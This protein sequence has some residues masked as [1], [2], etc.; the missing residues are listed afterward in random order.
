MSPSRAS[1]AIAAVRSTPH[2]ASAAGLFIA[3]MA[4]D[5]RLAGK[6]WHARGIAC[7]HGPMKTMD[8]TD[9]GRMRALRV[10]ARAPGLADAVRGRVSVTRL[11]GLTNATYRV[12]TEV[13]S[14]AVQM[15]ARDSAAAM[16]RGPAIAA[17]RLA[18]ALGIG[19]EL[20]H[21]EEHGGAIVT[22][23]IAATEATTAETLRAATGRLASLAASLARLHRSPERLDRRFD[24]F[25]AIAD[26]ASRSGGASLPP[27]LADA[28]RRAEIE[29]ARTLRAAVPV[30][31]DLV[32]ANVRAAPDGVVLIDWDYAGM[33]DPAWDIAYFALEAGL[34][35]EEEQ[36]LAAAHGGPGL[37]TRRLRLNRMTVATL[38][39]MWGTTRMRLSPEPDLSRWID[40]RRGE[41]A[42]LATSL[43]A[44][45]GIR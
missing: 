26:L 4:K 39:W 42:T 11:Q 36:A 13:G 10:L 28:L 44:D 16:A 8:D 9:P 19:A 43:Y 30:H 5:F 17:T 7:E 29:L 45:A 22:R 38:A 34:T 6:N 24:P 15:P 27:P 35:P 40:M 1:I 41:A 23:W 2:R 33:G 14:F 20:V 37:E 31:G 3:A 18:H 21:A 12:E 25:A 32:P